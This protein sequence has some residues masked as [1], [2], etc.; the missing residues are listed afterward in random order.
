MSR[1]A[2][3]N[4]CAI[5]AALFLLF[6]GILHSIVNVSG[7][8]RAIERGDIPSRLGASSIANAA[9]SG[10][11][12]SML[13]LLLLLV[14]PGLRAGSRHACRVASAIGI[15][16]GVVGAAGYAWAPTRPQVLIFVLFGALLAV[17]LLIWRREFSNA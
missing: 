2:I 8:Q 3:T 9:F 4:F 5:P 14:L 10:L 15:F 6:I 7:M 17:P 12:M 11:A 1:R 16:V 13:G